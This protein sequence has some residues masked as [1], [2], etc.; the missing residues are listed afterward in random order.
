MDSGR[1]L[2]IQQ[3]EKLIRFLVLVPS[4]LILDFALWLVVGR[5]KLFL[6]IGCALLLI[7]ILVGVYLGMYHGFLS[8]FAWCRRWFWFT[9]KGRQCLKVL[10][11][12]PFILSVAF[13]GY[14]LFE[15]LPELNE[16]LC[17]MTAT[18]PVPTIVQN[19]NFP[20]MELRLP[21]IRVG[22][23]HVALAIACIAVVIGSFY[24]GVLRGII[25]IPVMAVYGM[26]F[27]D[28]CGGNYPADAA[29]YINLLRNGLIILLVSSLVLRDF[30]GFGWLIT[31][32][33]FLVPFTFL[34]VIAILLQDADPAGS[35]PLNFRAVLFWGLSLVFFTSQSF[36]LLAF[37]V[38][39]Y[40]GPERQD[41][42]AADQ[43]GDEYD[44][45]DWW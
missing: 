14:L 9:D 42:T 12:F 32:V 33:R 40:G 2:T 34:C 45:S 23:W 5:Q 36:Q 39:E 22:F 1:R 29:A 44:D 19:I 43:S 4:L 21:D 25:A 17:R 41:N 28:A 27:M 16:L 13:T 8:I 3:K 18:I 24:S 11:C 31:T 37:D 26:L 7:L 35:P 10:L 15:K 20:D 30:S 38:P 6:L